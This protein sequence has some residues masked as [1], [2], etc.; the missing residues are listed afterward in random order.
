MMNHVISKRSELYKHT[1]CTYSKP[2]LFN[3]YSIIMSEDGT[4]QGDPESPPLSDEHK[5]SKVIRR[6]NLLN[7]LI[8]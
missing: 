2:N 4:Q 3:G 6:S 1:H 5:Q 7:K 8:K